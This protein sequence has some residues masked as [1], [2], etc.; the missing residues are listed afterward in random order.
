MEQMKHR[1]SDSCS[2]CG[3]NTLLWASCV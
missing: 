1:E 3:C 2:F